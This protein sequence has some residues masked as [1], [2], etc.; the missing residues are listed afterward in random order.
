VTPST[1]RPGRR[2]RGSATG[3]PVMAALD[4]LGRR[5]TLRV[6]WELRDGAV[7]FRPLQQRC[8][9]M[10][11]SVLQ[12]R[13]IELQQGL[14][15]V[16]HRDGSYELTRLGA[17]LYQALLP[18]H[19]WSDRW[20]GAIDAIP[21]LAPE[22][23][24]CAS[25]RLSYPQTDIGAAAHLLGSLPARYRRSVDGLSPAALR[26][27]PEPGTWSITEYLCH[28]RDVFD[29]YADRISKTLAQ[30]HPVL[31]P[32]HNDRRA[33]QG[34]YNDQDVAEVLDALTEG[35]VTLKTLIM[36]I[37]PAQSH[38]T[39]TRLPGE[40]RTLLWLVRQAA[41]EGI[42]HLGDIERQRV[43]AFDRPSAAEDRSK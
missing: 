37:S 11:S 6:L 5:W 20:A 27:R 35:A 42:H 14:L 26:R 18:L 29:V 13:L 34:H 2:V 10:S 43:L 1:P 30:E 8:G 9:G 7:G 31:E 3:R 22:D 17:D 21:P 19:R 33:E 39:A 40:Q 23:H 25:C 38:R 32:M 28:V 16:R 24:V 12:T 36:T 4:L 15:V 41:H